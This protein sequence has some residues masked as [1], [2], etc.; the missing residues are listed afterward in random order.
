MTEDTSDVTRQYEYQVIDGT[1]ES[2]LARETL[3][4]LQTT[5][6]MEKEVGEGL[7]RG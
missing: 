7:G 2:Q 5:V 6:H 1:Q 3:R 4:R